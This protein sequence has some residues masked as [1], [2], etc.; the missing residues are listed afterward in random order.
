V[1]DDTT[2]KVYRIIGNKYRYEWFTLD[3]ALIARHAMRTEQQVKDAVNKLVKDGYLKW[4]KKE[5]R[6]MVPFK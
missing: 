2:R 4:D 3:V 5:N 6:F 1:L